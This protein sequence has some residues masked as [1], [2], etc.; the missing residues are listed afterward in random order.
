MQCRNKGQ[1]KS[2]FPI[3]MKGY[4]VWFTCAVNFITIVSVIVQLCTEHRGMAMPMEDSLK[5]MS[6]DEHFFHGDPEVVEEN[7]LVSGEINID[8]SSDYISK[9]S[10]VPRI[11]KEV[12]VWEGRSLKMSCQLR[13]GSPWSKCEW[14]HGD[15]LLSVSRG[16][17]G[18]YGC[19]YFKNI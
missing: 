14:K 19:V 15:N 5:E 6:I 10:F 1:F 2:Q 4:F 8:T 18:N 16:F 7:L 12:G 13:D 9:D 17:Y 11:E 3:K